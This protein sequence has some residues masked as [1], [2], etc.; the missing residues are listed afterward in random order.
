MIA[1]MLRHLFTVL[2]VVSLLFFVAVC[3]FWYRSYDR[4]DSL[5]FRGISG[6]RNLYSRQCH[7]VLYVL[8]AD[9]SNQPISSFGFHYQR[10]EPAPPSRDLTTRL[11][12][13]PDSG[14]SDVFWER[15]QFAW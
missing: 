1:R 6:T 4:T 3:V 2:A 8:D 7:V 5:S 14:A 11:F 12:L 9:W 15:G 10:D 13:F